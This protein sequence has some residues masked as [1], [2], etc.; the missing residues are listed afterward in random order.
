MSVETFL[1]W[2]AAFDKEML[3]LKK[4]V[5]EDGSKKPTGKQLF[6]R[7]ESL[8]NDI[9]LLSNEDAIEVDES[10]FQDLENLDLEDD[11]EDYNPDEDDENDDDE[12]YEDEEEE[13]EE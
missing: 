4:Q 1:K 7:D 11:G 13:E 6:E 9:Q 10:L 12:D 2:K 8:F 5:K 3:E